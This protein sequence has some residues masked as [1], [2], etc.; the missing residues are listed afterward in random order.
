MLTISIQM[1]QNLMLTKSVVILY[2]IPITPCVTL[3][4]IVSIKK[5]IMMIKPFQLLEKIEEK[6][7]LLA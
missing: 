6:T 4:V 7:S 2:G 5:M 3:N 1:D